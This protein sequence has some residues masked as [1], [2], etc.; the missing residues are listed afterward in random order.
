MRLGSTGRPATTWSIRPF[1]ATVSHQRPDGHCG[2]IIKKDSSSFLLPANFGGPCL[3]TNSKSAPRS[4]DPC[5]K[6]NSGHPAA[7]FSPLGR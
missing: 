4:P 5:R 6:T 1:T 7:G 2:A 3:R